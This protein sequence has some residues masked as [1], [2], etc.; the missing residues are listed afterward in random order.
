MQNMSNDAALARALQEEEDRRNLMMG[1][2]PPRQTFDDES[3]L[4]MEQRQN[5]AELAQRM[6]Q[7]MTDEE[8][9]RR[10]AHA[11][12]RRR[13]AIQRNVQ[14]TWT[15]R[16]VVTY[17]TPLLFVAIGFMALVFAMGG[18]NAIPI[19]SDPALEDDF[20]LDEDP[21]QGIDPSQVN[22][23]DVNSGGLSLKVIN[24]VEDWWEPYFARAMKEWENGDPDALTLTMQKKGAP[25]F[26]CQPI[27]GRLKVCNGDYGDTRWRGINQILVSNNNIVASAA[28]MNDYFLKG[29]SDAQRQYTMCHELGHGFGLPHD[30]EDFFNTDRNNCMDYTSNPVNNQSPNTVNYQFLADLYGTVPNDRQRKLRQKQRQQQQF[31]KKDEKESFNLEMED[32][33]EQF[34]SWLRSKLNNAVSSLENRKDGDSVE[35]GW[36][37]LHR[38]E[39]GEAHQ[40]EL[41]EGYSVQVHLLL[42]KPES[43]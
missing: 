17:F 40:M 33:V 15:A 34:P 1:A 20:W 30:D 26:Q 8:L 22:K 25:D 31:Q 19:Q 7:Q 9:A 5:D 42:N 12:E 10:L 35:D 23:W 41:G 36:K 32:A 13:D 6:Q 16:R 18:R 43:S 21:F 14:N 4:R 2:S 37:L 28:R 3:A 29:A 27:T 39:H 38:H 24:S 11:D